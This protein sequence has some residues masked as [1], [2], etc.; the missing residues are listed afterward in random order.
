MAGDP[1]TAELAAA[2]VMRIRLA[3][4]LQEPDE[5]A[6]VIAEA[7]A[8]RMPKGW[9]IRREMAAA[10]AQARIGRLDAA[11]RTAA[12]LVDA[13]DAAGPPD[14]SDAAN[15]T[16]AAA[17]SAAA[18]LTLAAAL[19]ERATVV[20]G[21]PEAGR[22]LRTAIELA[23]AVRRSRPEDAAAW[24]LVEAVLAPTGPVPDPAAAARQRRQWAELADRLPAAA[25]EADR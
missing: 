20:R 16:D 14:A 21:G 15:A 1:S 11:V 22:D 19:V 4:L 9:E 5:L 3:G 7:R 13:V 12:D 2:H 23:S 6:R 25:R 18:R 10:T 8:V 24:M 17:L